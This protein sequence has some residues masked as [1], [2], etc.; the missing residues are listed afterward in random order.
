MSAASKDK[1][2]AAQLGLKTPLSIGSWRD[3]AEDDVLEHEDGKLRSNISGIFGPAIKPFGLRGVV[4]V[5]RV[6]DVPISGIGGITKWQDAVEYMLL[7]ASTVQVGTAVMLFG[8]RIV[9]EMIRGL[10]EYMERKG[11]KT[12]NDFVGKTTDRYFRE[13][14]LLWYER[15]QPKKMVVNENKCVGCGLCFVACDAHTNSKALKI[16]N[17]V[18]KIDHNLCHTCQ[19]CQIVCPEEAI[20]IEWEP[21]YL[22]Q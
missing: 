11:Y 2:L 19:V 12:I 20:T 18:A 4:E 7:G 9:G 1:I 21:A 5:R 16:T 15:K 17:K 3:K 10:E 22:A 14:G 8:Y 13:P 6:T